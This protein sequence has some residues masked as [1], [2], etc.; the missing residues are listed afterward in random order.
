M[1]NDLARDRIGNAKSTTQVFERVP[2]AIQRSDHPW[3]CGD[4]ANHVIPLTD[5]AVRAFPGFKHHG[6]P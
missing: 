2:E 6:T 3:S 4:N 5:F 1:D